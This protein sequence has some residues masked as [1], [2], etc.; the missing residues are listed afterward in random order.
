[1]NTCLYRYLNCSLH[2]LINS[3]KL[4]ERFHSKISTLA[5]FVLHFQSLTRFKGITCHQFM[6][7]QKHM[8]V[9][10]ATMNWNQLLSWEVISNEYMI[11]PNQVYL[12]LLWYRVPHLSLF[13]FFWLL[14]PQVGLIKLV[15]WASINHKTW[16]FCYLMIIF[17]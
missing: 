15:I 17:S 6:K 14:E 9:T 7:I 2:L 5:T 12:L 11:L 16:T 4:N 13:F 8:N 1:M 3:K 10:S